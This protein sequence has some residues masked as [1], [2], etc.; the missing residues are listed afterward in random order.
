MQ[1]SLLLG[2]K[3]YVNF[4]LYFHRWVIKRFLIGYWK[5]LKTF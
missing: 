3:M 4:T 2:V 1:K 5:H